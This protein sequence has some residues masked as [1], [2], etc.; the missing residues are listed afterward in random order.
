MIVSKINQPTI[1]S[2]FVFFYFRNNLCYILWIH[3]PQNHCMQRSAELWKSSNICINE[4]SAI[5]TESFRSGASIYVSRLNGR[6][7]SNQRMITVIMCVY[8]NNYDRFNYDRCATSPCWK[9]QWT[10]WRH[11]FSSL[12]WKLVILVARGFSHD[13]TLFIMHCNAKTE[14]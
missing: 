5:C 8:F 7:C 11:F 1:C 13:V 6:A 9:R 14:I 2:L 12:S 3:R 4:L 10:Y